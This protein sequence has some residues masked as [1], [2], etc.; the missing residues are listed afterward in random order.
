MVVD[1]DSDILDIVQKSLKRWDLLSDGFTDPEAAL[2]KFRQNPDLYEL[3][4]S[5]FKMTP[6]SGFEFIE[7]VSEIKP[8]IKVLMMTAYFRDMLDIPV[9]LQG[10]LK[11]DAILQ[12]P[13]GIK[14]V[15][16]SV[17]KQLHRP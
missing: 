2:E 11:V 3:V 5:D 12:K 14:R 17:K 15:C 16:E 4:I 7:K 8:N 13:V 10:I 9:V 6:M 1:D